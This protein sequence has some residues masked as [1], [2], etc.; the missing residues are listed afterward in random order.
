MQARALVVAA[1]LFLPTTL[2]AQDPPFH[3]GQWAAQFTGGAS[4]LSLGVIKFRSPTRALVLDVRVSGF[5]RELFVED[6]LQSID[7]EASVVLRLGRRSYR[8]IGDK[9]VVLRSLGVLGGFSHSVSSV[10]SL[11]SSSSNGL[12]AG[13][14]ADVGAVYLVTPHFGIGATGTASITYTH[15]SGESPSG[16]QIRSWSLGG[17]TGITFAATLYF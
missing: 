10:P 9:V 7:S 17:N 13:L 15:S 6:T 3:A 11:G 12:N 14:F 16:I 1:S 8:S 4:F 2:F 5:H